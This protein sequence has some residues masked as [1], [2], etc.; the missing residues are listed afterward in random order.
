MSD[1]LGKEN[2]RRQQMGLPKLKTLGAKPIGQYTKEELEEYLKS[3]RAAAKQLYSSPEEQEEYVNRIRKR[4]ERDIEYGQ[5]QQKPRRRKKKLEKTDS[6]VAVDNLGNEIQVP[7]NTVL[8]PAQQ[9]ADTSQPQEQ[10]PPIQQQQPTQQ[11]SFSFKEAGRIAG[12]RLLRATFPTLSKIIDK[13]ESA[14]KSQTTTKAQTLLR[15]SRDLER[16]EAMSIGLES[17]TRKNQYTTELL[18]QLLQEVKTM[19]RSTQGNGAG[20]GIGSFL[21]LGRG[22]MRALPYAAGAAALAA[23]GYAAY[24]A[25]QPDEASIQ[26]GQEAI[27]SGAGGPQV[28]AQRQQRNLNEELRE[29]VQNGELTREEA[30]QISIRA[31]T[32]ESTIEEAREQARE[33]ATQRQQQRSEGPPRPSATPAAQQSALPSSYET[34]AS[35]GDVAQDAVPANDIELSKLPAISPIVAQQG[36]GSQQDLAAT[37]VQQPDDAEPRDNFIGRILTLRARKISFKSDMFDFTNLQGE[38]VAGGGGLATPVSLPFV[39]GGGG[40]AA[41][42]G[43][44]A[45]GG[46]MPST[47]QWSTGGGRISASDVYNFFIG[48]GWSPAVAAGMVA[49]IDVESSF[50][51]RAQG[52]NGRAH[53]LAQWTPAGGRRQAVERF[54]GMPVLQAPAQRQLEAIH[55]ELT[56]GPER[57]HAAAIMAARTPAEAAALID[58]LYERSDGRAR[59]RRMERAEQAARDFGGAATQQ[60]TPA[61]AVPVQGQQPAAAGGAAP[62]S[63]A[64]QAVPTPSPAG[65]QA[66]EA[67]QENAV[68]ERAPTAQQ[69]TQQAP[70]GSDRGTQPL[71]T[72]DYIHSQ[73]D[74]GSVEPD[75]AAERYARLFG[76]EAA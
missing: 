9:I 13:L 19:R 31:L 35:F 18:E 70:P 11:R 14:E 49:N 44:G 27:E 67:S 6:L 21:G 25:M 39:T 61:Q 75:D 69:Q 66:A 51:P 20:F 23:G 65:T 22:V 46:V 43:A 53:G 59:R 55:W 64:A 16:T 47:G 28:Q 33:L 36:K 1:V 54:L 29:M 32:G 58:Q 3:V 45:G 26:R 37:K 34:R 15:S 68:A 8:Q 57:R 62:A 17:L 71:Q 38:S 30:N 41:A 12:D 52:D 4:Y 10:Q 2:V 5:K 74:P 73:N 40:Q 56:Q 76:M 50:D 48:R 60:Q 24:S 63:P 42:Q 72:P 7:A